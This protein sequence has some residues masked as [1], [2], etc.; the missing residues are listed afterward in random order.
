MV[1]DN[2]VEVLVP[3]LHHEVVTARLRVGERPAALREAR[4]ELEQALARLDATLRADAGGPR[5]HGRVGASVLRPLRT[6]SDRAAPARRP[7]GVGD[8]GE[9]G[10]RARGRDPVPERLGVDAARVERRRRP[11]AE[12]LAREHRRRSQGALRR[13]RAASSRSRASGRGSSAAGSTADRGSRSRWRSRR[14]S[15]GRISSRTGPSSS[16]ASPPRRRQA[17]GRRGSRTSR[18][19]GTRTS[20][21]AATSPRGRTCTCRTCSRTSP[22]GTR[23]STTRAASTRRS[24]PVST[25]RRTRRRCRRDRRKCSRRPRSAATTRGTGRSG[26]RARSSPPRGSTAT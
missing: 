22:P 17:S 21:R 26:T 20:A 16:S 4:E 12:R 14:A 13:A 25:C 11:P 5:R 23:H 1:I 9:R 24:G 7:A 2:H 3:P 18:R 10:A 19:S 15:T 6:G 8:P